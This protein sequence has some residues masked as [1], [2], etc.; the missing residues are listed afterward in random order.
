MIQL[1][2]V[3]LMLINELIVDPRR[4]IIRVDPPSDLIGSGVGVEKRKKPSV[5][6][7]IKKRSRNRKL[8]GNGIRFRF[9]FRLLL[10]ASVFWFPLQED[11]KVFAI[12]IP[13]TSLMGTKL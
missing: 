6:V 3:S 7:Q 4:T 12:P 8:D 5:L 10:S 13:L 1:H 2:Y 11:R 9:W